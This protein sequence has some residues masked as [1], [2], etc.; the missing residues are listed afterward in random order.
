MSRP[1]TITLSAAAG[2]AII[3]RLSVYAPSRSDCEIL[4]QVLRWYFWLAAAIKEAKLSLK[5]LRAL[6]LSQGP[7][8]PTLCEPEV[9]S[10]STSSHGDDEVSGN[11]VAWDAAG[12]RSTEAGSK[13]ESVASA[14]ETSKLR[15]GHRP[16]TG[17]LGAEA[18]KAAERVECRHEELAVGQRCPVCGQGTLYALPAG[19]EV[20]I[21][22]HALLSAIRYEVEKL[23]CSACG[24][25]FT[26]GLPDGVSE[27]TYSPRARAVLAV[28]RY[29][30]GLPFSRIEAYQAMLGV[31]VPDATQWDQIEQVGDCAYVVFAQMEQVAAQGELI[32]Q[33]DTAVRILS[34]IQENIAIVAAAQ[35]QSVSTPK[36]RTGMHTTALVVK[37]GEHTAI[38]YYSSRRHAGE[39]L[40][41]LLA[42]REAGLDTPLAMSDALASNEVA[43]DAAVIRCHCLA[44][45]RRKFSD[46]VE[47]FP[48]ECQ[49]VLEVISAVFDHDEQARK[50]QLSPE[51]RLAYHQT[52]SR[53]LMD[54]LQRWLDTQI[55]DH[56][57]EPNSSLGKAI[58]YMQN[59]WGTLTRF[60]HIQGAPLDN[61]LAERALKLLFGSARTRS[62]TK[63]PI[64]PT[65]PACSPVSSPP[66][67]MRGSMRWSTWWRCKSTEARS[68][69]TRQHGCPGPMP[70]AGRR[71][72]PPAASR[73]P[74]GRARDCRSIAQ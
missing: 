34:L 31:P 18:Y 60:L 56:L 59:H 40:Q 7:Q 42:K 24:Q 38:L 47:V 70:A 37:V 55:D 54:G 46:L 8:P 35:A 11:G 14:V 67:S 25:I 23:R 72:R 2:E 50:E 74:S 49:V 52:Y 12:G 13:P 30:L 20:R 4:I 48:H 51:A 6:L 62:F 22:G 64:A 66:A 44:H 16:G 65:L 15:G 73:G 19:V 39:N 53:P 45:G 33:D 9:S 57:V 10:V 43:N 3:A 5:K 58:V 36:A 27:A 63:A 68:V 71:L 61:N 41:E 21:D 26:A 69:R 1:E 28:G 17:R 29:V 32:F